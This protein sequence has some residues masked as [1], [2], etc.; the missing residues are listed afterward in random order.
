MRNSLPFELKIAK[1]CQQSWQE[2][3]GTTSERHCSSCRKNVHNLAVM[4]S[5]G[6]VKTIAEANGHLCAR[7]TRR[8]DG[9]IITADSAE[10]SGLISGVAGALVGGA[11]SAGAAAAQSPAG[12]SGKAIVSGVV[13]GPDGRNLSMPSEVLFVRDGQ[14]AKRIVP[15]SAGAWKAEHEPGSYDVIMKSGQIFGERIK[16]VQL[17]A[18][19]QSFAPVTERVNVGHLDIEDHAPLET[20][21]VG[22]VVGIYRYPVSYLF[23]HPLLYVKNLRHNFG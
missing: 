5:R 8:A 6:I 14:I 9:S 20:V 10:R 1:P 17:H 2:M 12:Q 21:L 18:G 23:K 3:H 11:L 13:R 19:E 7:I 4:S 22:E 15:D 16:K